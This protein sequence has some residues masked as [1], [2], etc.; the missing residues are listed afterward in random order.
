MSQQFFPLDLRLPLIL[1]PK[2]FHL[3]FFPGNELQF[4]NL[5][6][7][8]LTGNS[9]KLLSILI[10]NAEHVQ[11]H[12]TVLFVKTKNQ[13]YACRAKGCSAVKYRL[14]LN[15]RELYIEFSPGIYLQHYYHFLHLSIL[16]QYAPINRKI[17]NFRKNTYCINIGMEQTTDMKPH[18]ACDG[19]WLS[20]H[21]HMCQ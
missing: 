10:K 18:D 13:E 14:Q 8:N 17:D 21:L 11:C 15:I 19:Q 2:F 16:G 4:M 6:P 5:E 1:H 3:R 9:C 7:S 12:E 20:H